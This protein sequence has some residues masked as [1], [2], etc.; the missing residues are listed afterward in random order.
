MR[1][2]SLTLAAASAAALLCLAAPAQ[3]ASY[4]IDPNHTFVTFEIDHNGTSTNRGRFDKVQGSIEFDRDAKTGQADI[5]VD[6]RSINTGTPGFDKHLQSADV[7]NAEQFATARFVSERFV[8]EDNGKINEIH[9]QLT[10]LGQTHPVTIEAERFN[11]YA[12]RM[13][14]GRET[15]GGD[16]ELSI[17]RTRWGLNYATQY[18]A[19]KDVKIIIQIEAAKAK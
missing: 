14:Q 13:L 1:S 16:F 9:G 15:C 19:A 2:R 6:M 17:D 7:F 4:T 10:L 3:A 8:F 18:G 11:C 12:N 5:S